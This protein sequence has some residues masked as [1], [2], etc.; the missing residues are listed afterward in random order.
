MALAILTITCVGLCTIN[1]S[2][3]SSTQKSASTEVIRENKEKNIPEKESIAPVTDSNNAK[4]YSDLEA[5]L[6]TLKRETEKE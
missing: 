4:R 3:E 5:V 2:Q 6:Q 1:K